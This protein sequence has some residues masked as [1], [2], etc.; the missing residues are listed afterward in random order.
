MFKLSWNLVQQDRYEENF[1]KKD[2]TLADFMKCL[3]PGYFRK[4]RACL[5]NVL[6]NLWQ[7]LLDHWLCLVF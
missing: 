4:M 2:Y 1:E 3:K 5:A 6:V 7:I